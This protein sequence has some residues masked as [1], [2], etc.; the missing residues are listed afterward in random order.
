MRT[1][2]SGKTLAYEPGGPVKTCDTLAQAQMTIQDCVPR[3]VE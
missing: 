1:R 2:R 3:V